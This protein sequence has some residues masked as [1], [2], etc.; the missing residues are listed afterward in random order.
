MKNEKQ[1]NKKDIIGGIRGKIFADK[2]EVETLT[3][4]NVTLPSTIYFELRKAVH[5]QAINSKPG[6]KRASYGDILQRVVDFD[7]L[8]ELQKPIIDKK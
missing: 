4:H 2:S 8:H 1:S 7:K 6:D 5:A 3:W